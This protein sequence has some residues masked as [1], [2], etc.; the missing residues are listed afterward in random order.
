MNKTLA[1]CV[2]IMT[3]VMAMPVGAAEIS[4]HVLDIT[5]GTGGGGVPVTL[6]RRVDGGGW[7]PVATV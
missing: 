1:A 5:S 4:T 7:M 2:A 6:S 3:A